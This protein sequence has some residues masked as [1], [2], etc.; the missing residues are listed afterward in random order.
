MGKRKEGKKGRQREKE[1]EKKDCLLA[2]TAAWLKESLGTEAPR[3]TRNRN[4]KN[5]E[6]EAEN[7]D[8]ALAFFEKHQDNSLF[9]SDKL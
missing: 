8:V 3:M 1:R 2:G 6:E 4:A 9:L 7:D 5:S